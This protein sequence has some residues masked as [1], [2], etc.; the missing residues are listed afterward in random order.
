MRHLF[1]LLTLSSIFLIV[2]CTQPTP[3]APTSVTEDLF[4][5]V[6]LKRGQQVAAATFATLSSNLQKAMQEGG[7]AHAVEYCRLS[8]APL[9]DSLEKKYSAKIRRTSL[10]VRNPDNR[11]TPHELTQLQA[12]QQQLA[13]GETL[14]AVTKAI[15]DD[16]MAFYAP[17]QLM[18]LCQK[19]HGEMGKTLANTDYDLIQ[20]LYP[21]D[22]ATG[23]RT[24]D[25]RGMWSITFVKDLE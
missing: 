11:P 24:G 4:E 14:S 8:A 12:Y 19:C 17:I 13:A 15:G 16:K 2:H 7:V 5:A 10:K 6:Y 9:V 18:P 3:P 21:E 22:Q 23:Y 20:K 25:W 1:T